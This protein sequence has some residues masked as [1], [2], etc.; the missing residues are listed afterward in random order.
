MLD[1]GGRS[2]ISDG[3]GLLC[4]LFFVVELV[5]KVLVYLVSRKSRGL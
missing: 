3:F 4:F 2:G 1:I 5:V